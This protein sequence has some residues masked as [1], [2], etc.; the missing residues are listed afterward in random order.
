MPLDTLSNYDTQ[1]NG[2]THVYKEIVSYNG[3]GR[4]EAPNTVI[5]L[6]PGSLLEVL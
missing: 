3:T 5:E 1:T 4:S 6:H 2:D